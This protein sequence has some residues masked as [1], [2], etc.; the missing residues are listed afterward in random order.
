MRKSLL[1]ACTS[2]WGF[3]LTAVVVEPAKHFIDD[4]I[5]LA[6]LLDTP[7]A[8]MKAHPDWL[9]FEFI[10]LGLLTGW[11]WLG[12]DPDAAKPAVIADSD[13]ENRR[14]MLGA[15]RARI[16]EQIEKTVNKGGEI[17]LGFVEVPDVLVKLEEWSR[18]PYDVPTII[19]A[20][21]PVLSIFKKFGRHLLI[22]GAPGAGKTTLLRKLSRGLVELA[23]KDAHERIP[24]IFELSTWTT[25]RQPLTV[26]MVERLRQS[27]RVPRTVAEDWVKRNQIIPLLDGLDEVPQD[28]RNACV[29]AI[30]RYRHEHGFVPVAV[31][32][33]VK[34]YDSIGQKLELDG[35]VAIRPLTRADVD[36]YLQ[37]LG[38]PLEGVRQMLVRDATAWELLD[39]P[40]M[41]DIL[42]RSYQGVPTE[43]LALP[44]DIDER[45]RHLFRAYV[46][47]MFQHRSG[48]RYPRARV[49]YWLAWLAQHLHEKDFYL[50]DLQADWLPKKTRWYQ[51]RAHGL[52][53]GLFVGR[54]SEKPIVPVETMHWSWQRALRGGALVGDLLFG[55][56]FGLL[57]GMFGGLYAGMAYGMVGGL[58]VGL[59][60]GLL[61]LI[62]DGLVP[63]KIEQKL[64]PNQSIWAS[65]RNALF[66]AAIGLA[67]GLLFGLLFGLLVGL[68]RGGS[69][70]IRHF[71]LRA[72]L[73]FEGLAPFRYVPFLEY[74]TT[75]LFL[76][77]NGGA[78]RFRHERLQE[79]FVALT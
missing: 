75:L 9:G 44:G 33:R 26:W 21:T 31:C 48:S 62:I 40:L 8:F 7:W 69:A 54:R 55:L 74:A 59:V 50:E 63:G 19:P 49:E 28:H 23:E 29:D 65:L 20:D 18:V 61:S 77:R 36:D 79:Y 5:K 52:F 35:A 4:Q 68:A 12:K 57:V 11:A 25:E 66:F 1:T 46:N 15:M 78:Y 72:A 73:A 41:V 45:R 64:L 67:L 38:Q 51:R 58:F 6:H 13:Y 34:D 70:F 10:I 30:N 53:V 27:Y 17:G 2:F 43:A 60:A 71:I 37:Q 76:E 3:L 22:L 14:D 16:D 56:F 47:R 39:T 32:C 24:V 42:I